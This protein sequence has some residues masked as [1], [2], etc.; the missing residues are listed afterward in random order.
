M[1]DPSIWFNEDAF[2]NNDVWFPDYESDDIDKMNVLHLKYMKLLEEH[3]YIVHSSMVSDSRYDCL[4]C[5]LN[6]DWGIDDGWYHD[7]KC[8]DKY[9]KANE[10]INSLRANKNEVRDAFSNGILSIKYFHIDNT[11]TICYLIQ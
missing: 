9:P 1:E 2:Y 7:T 6:K 5:D 10:K 3:G 4:L 8:H 11:R